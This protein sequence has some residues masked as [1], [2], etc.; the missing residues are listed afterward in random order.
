MDSSFV[1]KNSLEPQ[2]RVNPSSGKTHSLAIIASEY[3]GTD[4]RK[5]GT[6]TGPGSRYLEH[7][8]LF[9]QLLT[10]T[11]DLELTATLSSTS[12]PL[13][14]NSTKYEPIAAPAVRGAKRN[15]RQ[16]RS[17]V[18]ADPFVVP[19]DLNDESDLSIEA[20][21]E[22]LRNQGHRHSKGRSQRRPYTVDYHLVFEQL[23]PEAGKAATE[24]A[25][26]SPEVEMESFFEFLQAIP[27]GIE[28]WKEQED[29]S[30]TTL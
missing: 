16:L 13:D 24:D 7:G 1:Y 26:P 15:T 20:T 14:G 30:M 23:F 3:A 10:L 6:G 18:E 19:D 5:G 17:P 29:N 28:N 9:Y 22:H 4:I 27:Q 12:L 21:N 2:T 25:S 8:I 11:V